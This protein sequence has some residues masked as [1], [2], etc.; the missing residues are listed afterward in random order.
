MFV[1]STCIIIHTLKL[2]FK[3][4]V[5]KPDY[6]GLHYPGLELLASVFLPF[7]FLLPTLKKI[8]T[9]FIKPFI[10]LFPSTKRDLH[11][12]FSSVLSQDPWSIFSLQLTFS[13]HD[14][15]TW[16]V[17]E[18]HHGGCKLCTELSVTHISYKALKCS[19]RVVIIWNCT[20]LPDVLE[21]VS[22]CFLLI[23]FSPLYPNLCNSS[24][25]T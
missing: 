23:H 8:I 14:P 3:S 7:F 5:S 18:F 2:D 6:L 1:M 22:E 16:N 17:S 20:H 12:C 4:I 9:L 15:L 11:V 21:G 13:F 19:F 24:E 10:R 25:P